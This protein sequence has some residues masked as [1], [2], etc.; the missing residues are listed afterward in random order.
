MSIVVTDNYL[1][2]ATGTCSVCKEE[3]VEVFKFDCGHW[4]CEGCCYT[5]INEDNSQWSGCDNCDCPA[6][7]EGKEPE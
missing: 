3:E 5:V 2:E 1:E 7:A 6:R 4:A